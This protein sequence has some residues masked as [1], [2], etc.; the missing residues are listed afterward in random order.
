[1]WCYAAR[2]GYNIRPISRH[3]AS[4][5]FR[6]SRTPSPP[7]PLVTDKDSL[8]ITL[9]VVVVVVL[10]HMHPTVECGRGGGDLNKSL[11]RERRRLR[12]ARKCRGN[13]R[14]WKELHTTIICA[15]DNDDVM[16]DPL[17]HLMRVL[18]WNY[19]NSVV[20]VR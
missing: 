11:C 4:S 14:F 2:L 3:F 18:Q 20:G 12:E 5:P 8:V 15:S 9:T 1:M 16:G 13:R 6:P 7:S 17:M 10:N 19:V